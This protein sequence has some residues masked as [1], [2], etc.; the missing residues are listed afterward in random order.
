MSVW[1]YPQ[2]PE[3]LL[4]IV[5]GTIPYGLL[6]A[7]RDSIRISM[8]PITAWRG[9]K[10]PEDSS[11]ILYR[12]PVVAKRLDCC[13]REVYRLIQTGALPAVRVGT[14]LRVP[15]AG[16]RALIERQLQQQGGVAE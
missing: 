10:M 11:T 13:V 4:W 14:L 7:V 9:W 12:I 16:L 3:T 6:Q 1:S 2:E 8:H 5:L 15:E